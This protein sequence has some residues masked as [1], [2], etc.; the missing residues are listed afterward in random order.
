M[1]IFNVFEQRPP[2][3]C[4]LLRFK[5]CPLLVHYEILFVSYIKLILINNIPR[6]TCLANP[7]NLWKFGKLVNI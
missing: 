3:Q 2:L 1:L 6:N 4:A 5:E 7:V